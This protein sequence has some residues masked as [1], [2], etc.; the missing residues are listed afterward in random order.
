MRL[1][2]APF[3][4]L[5]VIVVGVA[6]YFAFSAEHAGTLAFWVLAA[7]PSVVLAG[8]ASLWAAREE[9]LRD[10]LSPKWGD[11]TRGVVGAV[12]FFALAWAFARLV[13]PV[14]SAREIWLV[15][16]YAQLGDPRALQAH[17]P[18]LAAT[19]AVT[20]LAEEVLWRGAVAQLLAAH[21]GSRAAWVW[22]AVLYALAYVPTMFSLRAG[23]GVNPVLVMGALAGGLLWG[24]M[25]RAFGRLAP[26]VLAH[27]LFDWAIIMMFPLWGR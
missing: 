4:A 25:A 13:A 22:A 11:F 3:T 26:A 21:V 15:S 19:I 18:A 14:G 5:V 16:L 8:A 24:A 12:L 20:A 6:S 27:A 17:A 2:A 1:A 23:A 10:W 7:A 9:L